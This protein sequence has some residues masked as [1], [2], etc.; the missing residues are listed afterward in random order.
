MNLLTLTDVKT[1]EAIARGVDAQGIIDS[2]YNGAGHINKGVLPGMPAADDQVLFDYDPAKAK[3]L[4][5]ASSWD[6]SKPLR[7]VFDKS[8]AG[9]EQWAPIMQQNL[10]AIGFKV[11]LMGLDTTAAIETYDKI[12]HLRRHHRPGRRAGRRPVP[13]ADLLQLQADRAGPLQDLFAE[14][15]HRRWLRRR[16]QGARPHQ[17][18]RDLQE[19][20]QADQQRDREGLLVDDQ[21]PQRE[22]Q[23]SAGCH[24]PA[25][26]AGVHHRRPE[27]DPHPV[28]LAS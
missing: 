8:F 10:E 24:D 3:E 1:R 14:L 18:E 20:Q 19:R 7:I 23:A 26:H 9:V 2:I 4:L 17:A 22:D 15:R 27:L 16:P 21:C 12:D 6:K 28:T 25:G 13:V 5:D 11:E